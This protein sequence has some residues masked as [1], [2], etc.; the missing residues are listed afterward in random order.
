[1]VTIFESHKMNNPAPRGEI[2]SYFLFSSAARQPKKYCKRYERSNYLDYCH[3]LSLS[4]STPD[5]LYLLLPSYFFSFPDGV[6]T[7]DVSVLPR[8]LYS[9]S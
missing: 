4:T 3:G 5:F 7:Y 6:L 1:M 8:V 9:A 2:S